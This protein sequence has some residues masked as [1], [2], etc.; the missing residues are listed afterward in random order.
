MTTECE[1]VEIMSNTS[2]IEKMRESL[3]E[4]QEYIASLQFDDPEES[5]ALCVHKNTAAD[6]EEG[7]ETIND[8]IMVTNTEMLVT[9]STA[10]FPHKSVTSNSPPWGSSFR[11]FDSN[12]S[13]GASSC[14]YQNHNFLLVGENEKLVQQSVAADEVGKLIKYEYA[15]NREANDWH[16]W[17]GYYWKLCNAYDVDAAI[18]DL[19]RLGAG[20][21][22]FNIGYQ[23]GVFG[24][25]KKLKS[26]EL[27]K[28]MP[29]TIPFQNG[30][31]V[32]PT[33][34]LLPIAPDNAATWA[35]PFEYTESARCHQF[36]SWLRQAVD[37]DEE[38]V[39]F[40]RAYIN[41]VLVGRPE[42]QIFL[43]IIGPG[44]TG[45]STFGR[46]LFRLVGDENAT[47]VTDRPYGAI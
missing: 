24:I 25:I 21:K 38:T 40:L 31:L 46:M 34:Q 41:A 14:F 19:I 9:N 42:L 35:L 45:K 15:Y 23:R 36:I 4:T 20:S 1:R 29:E 10:E 13:P 32:V 37:G 33:K 17:F 26:I 39:Q 8:C 11:P 16:I 7:T 27:P 12:H 44:G 6:Q 22:G 5:D 43:H 18:T 2:R 28:R 47:T 3:R 30:L